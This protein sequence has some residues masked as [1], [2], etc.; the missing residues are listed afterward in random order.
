M[1]ATGRVSPLAVPATMLVSPIIVALLWVGYAAMF[2][3]VVVPGITGF[4]GLVVRTLADAALSATHWLDDL[5]LSSM[6]AP[7]TPLWWAIPATLL[8]VL[9]ARFAS[10]SRRGW[11]L[12]WSAL[13]G[14]LALVWTLSTGLT[15][16]VVLRVDMLNVGDGTCMIVRTPDDT[17]LWD[18]QNAGRRGVMPTIVSSARAL[19]IAHIPRVL[20][21]HPDLDHFAGLPD[22]IEPLSVR[23]VIVGDRFIRAADAEPKSGAALLRTWCEE[24]GARMKA[25]SAGDEIPLAGARITILAPARGATWALD[26]DHSLVLLIEAPTGAA[27][28]RLL[29][30]GDIQYDALG[31]LMGLRIPSPDAVETPHHGAFSERAAQWL[32]TLDPRVVLQ[33][34]GPRRDTEPRWNHLRNATAWLSTARRGWCFVEWLDDG[35]LRT[36]SMR[37]PARP[38]EPTSPTR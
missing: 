16:G 8:L 26:N 3:G 23:E 18:C 9:W 19:G 30:T 29:L 37:D 31:S 14:S 6:I 33:S 7:A 22:V 36:G 10:W 35:T 20:I 11:I 24:R 21:S 4:A 32:I 13:I 38:A 34:T 27:P 15:R 2:A 17:L 5:P 12:A 28:A 1:Y 25:V